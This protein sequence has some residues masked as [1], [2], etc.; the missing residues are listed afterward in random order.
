MDKEKIELYQ[1]IDVKV[2]QI[3]N[4]KKLTS[5]Y[6]DQNE[7]LDHENQILNSQLDNTQGLKEA[8]DQQ[9]LKMTEELKYL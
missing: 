6:K 7:K 8:K 2:Y 1:D 3:E 4:Q 5:K 9:I